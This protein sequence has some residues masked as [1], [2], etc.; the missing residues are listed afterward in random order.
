MLAVGQQVVDAVSLQL[1]ACL[2]VLREVAHRTPGLQVEQV[3]A[4]AVE[5]RQ[6]FVAA[7]GTDHAD[8]TGRNVAQPGGRGFTACREVPQPQSRAEGPGPEQ[9]AP[10]IVE[11]RRH[12][13]FL[14]YALAVGRRCAVRQQV[15]ARIRPDGPVAVPEGHDAVDVQPLQAAGR[16]FPVEREGPGIDLEQPRGR[17]EP[18]PVRGIEKEVVEQHLEIVV[19]QVEPLFEGVGP[20]VVK[21]EFAAVGE[22]PQPPF[23]VDAQRRLATVAVGQQLGTDQRVIAHR[24][25]VETACARARD[26]PHIAVGVFDHVE[27]RPPVE[28]TQRSGRRAP[29]NMGGSRGESRDEAPQQCRQ[30]QGFESLHRFRRKRLPRPAGSEKA[31]SYEQM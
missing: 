11:N 10:G 5:S 22:G 6:Q 28:R 9:A 20:G 15:N 2:L 14:Q 25:A 29:R 18:Q 30:Q 19:R 13:V 23:A 17:A 21:E 4:A 27:H 16:P 8:R 31:V 1:T 12:V 7:H 3:D 26:H 24:A